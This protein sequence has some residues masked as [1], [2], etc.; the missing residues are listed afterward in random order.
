MIGNRELTAEDYVAILRRRIWWLVVPTLVLAAASL[1][2]SFKL[3]T[4]Y[5]SQT[6]VL[7][8][9]Q[10]VPDA[11]VKPVVTEELQ[12]RLATMQEQ[13]LSRTRLQ[14]IIER[15]GLFAD[16][17]N[18]SMEE[19]VDLMRKA[20][21]VTPVKAD[22]ATAGDKNGLPG[23]YVSFTASN[24]RLAQNVCGEITSMF[25]DENLKVRTNAAQGTTDF[26]RS[27]VDDAKRSLDEQDSKLAEFKK[28]FI[29]QLPGQ[30]QSNMNM[31]TTLNTQLDAATQ[32]LNRMQQEKT[33]T[34]SM[35]TQQVAAWRASESTDAPQTLDQQLAA[36]EAELIRLQSRYTETHPDVVKAKN[37]V[38]LLQKKI[39]DQ[40]KQA[41][42]VDASAAAATAHP[43]GPEPQQIQQLRAQLQ[44][45]DTAIKDKQ[46]EQST[47]L[48]QIHNY[49]ARIQLS[50]MVEEQYKE[51][52][53]DYNT[54]LA[55]YNDLLSKKNQSEM[56]TDLER[57][58]QGEQ[59]SVMDPP[60]LPEKPTF[61]NRPLF[62]AG[63]GVG[64]FAIG[65][66]IALLLEMKDKSLRTDR[67]VQFFLE[68]PTLAM[69]PRI[70]QENG[71]K[72]ALRFWNRKKDAVLAHEER[73]LIRA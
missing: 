14:P 44:G 6:L 71:A 17:P 55:F 66:F 18:L 1:L 5:T 50:P 27:Q 31:L 20:I 57:K 7:V 64:G 3:E 16:R 24:P 39:A 43:K 41:A 29:G 13:I 22:F 72:R 48:G 56:A 49:Q 4:R 25:M 60:N 54:A 47:I 52:T 23:F 36:A 26:L 40:N 67:D 59:F 51:L 8:Q 69:L 28:K 10:R 12:Q 46:K 15:F 42:A 37:N 32:A 45:L 19:K 33:Y 9:Q 53:R 34:E 62:A 21:T 11:F 63:G 70:G 38:E 65:T 61:P 73:T 30:E 35:L 58:Q 2:L 68:L